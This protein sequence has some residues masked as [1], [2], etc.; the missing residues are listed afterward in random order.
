L[1]P[2]EP[3]AYDSLGLSYQAAGE[4]RKALER[5]QQ[6]LNLNPTFEIAIVHVGNTQIMLGQYDKAITTINRYIA[7]APT[8]NERYR[9]YDSLAFVY[10]LKGSLDRALSFGLEGAKIYPESISSLYLVHLA[11]GRV[12]KAKQ[13]ERLILKTAESTNRG[14][15]GNRRQ[16]FFYRGTA[17]LSNGENETAIDYFRQTIGEPPPVLHYS[18]F[19]DCLGNAYLKLGRYDEA[20]VEFQRILVKN[21]NY[22]LAQFHLGQAFQSKGLLDQARVAYQAFLDTWSDAD[23]D[24]PE[25]IAA[26]NTL[27]L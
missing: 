8:V 16:E 23:S 9:G 24:V 1:S 25:V 18:D 3:N 13:M 20:I 26:K 21:Q 6:A 5:Y 11:M 14:S 27:N 22:P 19:E 10:L 2:N 12:E 4:Y 15:R 17:A 7:T